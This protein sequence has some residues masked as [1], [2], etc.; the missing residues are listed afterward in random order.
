MDRQRADGRLPRRTRASVTRSRFCP[1]ESA[2]ECPYTGSRTTTDSSRAQ[3][4]F[5]FTILR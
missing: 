1:R 3:C 2:R 5:R 4:R